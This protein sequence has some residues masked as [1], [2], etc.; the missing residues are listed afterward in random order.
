M[1]A[2]VFVPKP[3]N[4]LTSWLIRQ[5][6]LNRTE[7][8]LPLESG[9]AKSCHGIRAHQAIS[10][11]KPNPNFNQWKYT[12]VEGQT[13]FRVSISLAFKTLVRTD[14]GVIYM[15]SSIDTTAV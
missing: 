11:V 2:D 9:T 8:N 3:M 12:P 4:W 7:E 14:L 6:C 15:Q 5:E 10:D 13:R 1:R